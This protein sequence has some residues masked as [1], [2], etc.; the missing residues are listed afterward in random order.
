VLFLTFIIDLDS[1]LTSSVSTFADDTKLF[2]RVNNETDKVIF[3]K[4][5]H[6]LIEWSNTWQMPFNSFKCKVLHFGASNKKFSYFMGTHKSHKLDI[7]NEE[8]DL[9]VCITNNLR[10][11][12]QCQLAYS[13]ANKVLELN[14]RT[15]SYKDTNVLLK[16][17]KTLVRPHLE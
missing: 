10:S 16:L 15:I 5:L 12:R 1:A 11:A 9:G 4:D 14:T 3:Q 17:Y 7:M 6:Q 2:A 13:E 8:K